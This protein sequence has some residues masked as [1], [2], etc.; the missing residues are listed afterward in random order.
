MKIY[1]NSFLQE[2]QFD[3]NH[4]LTVTRKDPFGVSRDSGARWGWQLPTM[5]WGTLGLILITVTQSQT[6]STGGPIFFYFTCMR[7]C[8][9]SF[10]SFQ[11]ILYSSIMRE[12]RREIDAQI[13]VVT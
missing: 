2:K 4:G 12:M 6:I 10:I 9:T 11:F 13:E 8:V 3:T 1:R 5:Q 7:R